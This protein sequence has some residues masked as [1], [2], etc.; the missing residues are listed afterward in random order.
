MLPRMAHFLATDSITSEY[1]AGWGEY[2]C[3]ITVVAAENIRT[4][5][6]FNSPELP[7][8]L[9]I[10]QIVRHFPKPVLFATSQDNV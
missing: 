7:V 2:V 8:G 3:E 5:S 6:H 1:T 9:K 10:K 4:F